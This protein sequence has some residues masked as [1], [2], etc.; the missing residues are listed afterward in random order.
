MDKIL[1]PEQNHFAT[2]SKTTHNENIN[3]PI[4]SSNIKFSS[5]I[6]FT[7]YN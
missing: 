1:T 7:E 2:T 6:H 4:L 3:Q 5:R